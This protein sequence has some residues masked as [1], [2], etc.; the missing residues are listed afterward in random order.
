M[1]KAAKF[2]PFVL[3]LIVYVFALFIDVMDVDS[4]QYAAMAKEMIDRDS[5]LHITDQ[6]RN[7]LDKPPLL[8]WLSAA[9]YHIFGVSTA[10]FKLPSMLF[11]LLAMVSVY[12]LAKL[13]YSEREAY[14]AA[15]LL[16]STQAFFL[17]VNDV[18]TDLMLTGSVIFAVWQ[19]AAYIEHRKVLNFVLGF[20]G[21]GLAM[22]AKGPIGI[23]LPIAAFGI[24]L[25]LQRDWKTI[26]NWRWLL[27]LPIVALVLLPMC[28]G[29]YNQYDAN[30]AVEVNGHIGESGLKFYFWTQSF[31]RITGENVWDNNAGPFFLTES[32]LWAFM[33][34]TIWLFAAWINGWYKVI[35]S[36]FKIEKGQEA[37]TLGGFTFALLALSKSSYQL[38]HY[39]FVAYPFAAIFAARWVVCVLQEGFPWAK[40]LIKGTQLLIA[41]LVWALIGV[42]FYVFKP[43]NILI[44]VLMAVGLIMVLYY[45][46]KNYQK[47]TS[48][49]QVAFIS[50]CLLNITMNLHFYPQLMRYQAFSMGGKYIAEKAPA[51]NITQKN[52][53]IFPIGSAHSLDF[54]TGWNVTSVWSEQ[55]FS[56]YKNGETV[57]LYTTDEGLERL[58][59]LPYEITEE[60]HLPYYK[61]TELRP[62]FLNPATR[63]SVV[64][65]HYIVKLNI[66]KQET[67]DFSIYV[68]QV[69]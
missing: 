33:P 6:G 61:T 20:V 22:L 54:Y 57:W 52:F 24:H 34:W 8:F 3:I 48:V 60:L 4:S 43:E 2:F 46:G 15:L 12:G 28:I 27:G 65:S 63:D 19:L 69:D 9:S 17:M 29:L 64:K 47:T 1:N 10:A 55:Y 23:V 38:P 51:E 58:K 25:V 18:R 68:P 41:A 66:Q 7:Y 5:Y 53:L 67:I 56:R 30:P 14:W 49:L 44:P 40:H 16:C 39:I 62:V 42:L 59:V 32:T 31:G 45:I 21:I 35:R 50:I 13:Y 37:I 26:F 36:K 11:A